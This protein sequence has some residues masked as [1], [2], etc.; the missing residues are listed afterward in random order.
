[1][2]RLAIV[3]ASIFV[4]ILVGL[5][6]VPF[7]VDVNQHRGRIQSEIEKR[8]GRQVSLG[9]LSLKLTPPT[10]S[11]A[12]AMV[13]EDMSFGGGI[14]A[15]AEQLQVSV[16][17]W[18]LL[19]RDIQVSSLELVR[20]RIWLIRNGQG[21]W[22]FSTLGTASTPTGQ[23][24]QAP[25]PPPSGGAPPQTAPPA[26]NPSSTSEFSLANLKV[27]D[28]Q[29][30]VKDEQQH[31]HA[32]YDH[33]D[34]ALRDFSPDK[35]FSLQAAAHLPGPG[36]ET[37]KLEAEAGP[38]SLANL[39]ETPLDGDVTLDSVSLSG[40]RKF[41]DAPALADV[42]GIASGKTHIKS[43]G[44]KLTAGGSLKLENGRAKVEFGYPIQADFRFGADLAGRVIRVD[45]GSLKLGPTPF[46]VTGAVNAGAT[47]PQLDLRLITNDA[48]IAEAARLASAFGVAFGAGIKVSGQ[49]A[50]DV[51][52]QG[53]ANNL[54]LSGSLTAHNLEASGG[55]LKQP[56]RVG[57]V[58]LALSPE[59][60]R[61][62]DFSAT[63]GGTTV[64]VRFALTKYTTPSP[65]LDISLKAPN[66][67]VGE[68]LSIAQAYGISAAD[69]ITGSG[70]LTMDVQAVGPLKDLAAMNFSGSGQLQNASF[71]LPSL[72]K[73]LGVGH[74]SLR[75]TQNS[76]VLENLAAAL[77]RTNA[78]G[79]VTLRNFAAPEVQFTLAANQLNVTAL[80][81]VMTNSAPSKKASPQ[82]WDVIPSAHAQTPGPAQSNPLARMT[83]QGT[84]T[85]G[86]ILYDQLVLKNVRSNVTLNKGVILLA[87]VT[88]DLYGG[89]QTGSI[90]ADTRSTPMDFQV[91]SSLKNVDANQLLSAM[92]SLK[93]TIFGSLTADS[94][95]TF[96]AASSEDI[97]RTLNG[98]LSVNLAK[99]RIAH[100]DVLNQLAALGRFTGNTGN[101]KPFTD[102][103]RMAGKFDVK[104]GVAETNDL[105]AIIQGGT[106]AATGKVNLGD[107]SLDMR[108]TAVLAKELSQSVGGTNI[109][110]YMETA[111][112]NN[113]G[114][115]VMPVLVTGT[116]QNP[117]FAPDVAKI[118]QMKL[119]NVLPS[120]S[121]PGQ[122]GGLKGL[123]GALG[124]K[125]QGAQPQAGGQPPA[126]QEGAQDQNSTQQADPLNQLLNQV[127]NKKKKKDE[128]PA[129][130]Q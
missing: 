26:H 103:I 107:Q 14:F 53:A 10:I 3:G 12:S 93:Q 7:V 44:G 16:K 8:L 18:P 110:G 69:G 46:A 4:V 41:L 125:G 29:I 24:G 33:I 92:S 64:G 105:Q 23:S 101:Q 91:A 104:N 43:E 40:L 130:P 56:V 90:V 57:S 27:S 122:L 22:N 81:Q 50:A 114:E 120:L 45:Q 97:A 72:T 48:S 73:P 71:K 84:L 58:E 65:T 118:A 21:K 35:R 117:R 78:T 51:R 61:S 83:G 70:E 126:Q 79:T 121:N 15:Q 86:T 89:Q 115:L 59:A 20:P 17:L 62:N 128:K 34:I 85:V 5:L 129:P 74:A 94:N 98:T 38:L 37:A 25:P 87:P 19:R 31:S 108:V 75:F 77:D 119:Q 60:I 52:A 49:L 82:A 88:A 123:L 1:M 113:R 68:L 11:V 106:L 99:G 127:L 47:P 95:T 13:R 112:A 39:L 111:L 102:V 36:V 28:G 63:A 124:G 96:H 66:A 67:N 80:Q 100:V 109:G 32:V 55:E 76:V 6:A 116:L 54:A 9:N 30:T 42:N 2:R